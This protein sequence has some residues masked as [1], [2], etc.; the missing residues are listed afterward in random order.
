VW[1]RL[2]TIAEAKK[3]F[4]LQPSAFSE[5]DVWQSSQALGRRLLFEREVR[6]YRLRADSLF[7]RFFLDIDVQ[8]FDFLIQGGKRD[9]E[10]LRRVGLIPVALLQHLDNDLPLAIFDDVE[11]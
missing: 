11:Q 10:T 8:A 2:R 6:T 3:A 5:K 9:V 7:F 1:P 4:S